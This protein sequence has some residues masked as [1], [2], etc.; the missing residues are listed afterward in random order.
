LSVSSTDRTTLVICMP[1]PSIS[2]R[3]SQPNSC[4]HTLADSSQGPIALRLAQSK[5]VGQSLG[6]VVPERTPNMVA[7]PKYATTN[8]SSLESLHEFGIAHTASCSSEALVRQE[9]HGAGGTLP[10][11]SDSAGI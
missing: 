11:L 6:R 10:T 7:W 3:N 9:R 1:W 8:Q 5:R 4:D 2:K